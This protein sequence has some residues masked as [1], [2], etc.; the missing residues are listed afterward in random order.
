MSYCFCQALKQLLKVIVKND[1]CYSRGW[2]GHSQ[3]CANEIVF[4]VAVYAKVAPF[5]AIWQQQQQS[6]RSQELR[7]ALRR[8]I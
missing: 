2:E 5:K 4:C 7:F 1:N 6:N 8:G 3:V